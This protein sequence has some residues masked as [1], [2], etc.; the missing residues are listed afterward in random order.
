MGRIGSVCLSFLIVAGG[1]T[2]GLRDAAQFQVTLGSPV[3]TSGSTITVP[4]EV[5]TAIT[6]G[7]AQMELSFDPQKLRW[8]GGE[9][10]TLTAATLLE[11]NLIAPGRAKLAFAGGD[12]VTGNGSLFLLTF[13]WIGTDRE[14][15]EIRWDGVR[16]WDQANGLEM[17]TS[18]QPGRIAPPAPPAAAETPASPLPP[19]TGPMLSWT[20]IAGVIGG[21]ILMILILIVLRSRPSRS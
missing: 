18:S 2:A 11:T 13:E 8:I 3:K 17:T 14:P 7:A 1:S 12:Q 6:A 21:G 9:A 4:V 19:A 10:G 15:A 20:M 5:Q 16:A